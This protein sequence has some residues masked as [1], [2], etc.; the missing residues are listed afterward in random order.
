MCAAKLERTGFVFRNVWP[1]VKRT[2]AEQPTTF[3]QAS[4]ESGF[5]RKNS[6]KAEVAATGHSARTPIPV[7]QRR[8]HATRSRLAPRQLT[9]NL[10]HA[11][12]PRGIATTPVTQLAS[13]GPVVSRLSGATP[14]SAT[15]AAAAAAD[16]EI[17]GPQSEQRLKCG[18][19]IDELVRTASEKYDLNTA[20]WG[21]YENIPSMAL[22]SEKQDILQITENFALIHRKHIYL[23]QRL[24]NT[25]LRTLDLWSAPDFAAL[26][27]SW[28][29]LGFLHEDLCVAM[30]ERVTSTAYTCNTQELC[31]LMDAYATARCSVHSVVTEITKQTLLRLEEPAT[32]VAGM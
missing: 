29:Q 13:F 22:A 25:V 19:S 3:A 15:S 12:Q 17:A 30:A 14:G 28:A 1:N 23:F 10:L 16:A 8:C 4:N 31:W 27:H 6:Q 20:F 32:W 11:S 5:V 18:V 26:C 24:K 9:S 21:R 7:V 2:F